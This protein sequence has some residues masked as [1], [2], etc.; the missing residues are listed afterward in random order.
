[1]PQSIHCADLGKMLTATVVLAS[2]LNLAYCTALAETIRVFQDGTGDYTDIPSGLDAAAE[3]D[4]VLVGAGRY[5]EVGDLQWGCCSS[6]TTNVP[7]SVPEIT[8]IGSGRDA[9]IIGPAVRAAD[10]WG[11]AGIAS[12]QP[13]TSLRV[14]SLTI[15]NLLF[16]IFVEGALDIWDLRIMGISNGVVFSDSVDTTL[17]TG[18]S[19]VN[20]DEAG[21]H[22]QSA[23]NV[24]VS[25]CE[26]TGQSTNSL[27]IHNS[28][29][30]HFVNSRSEDAWIGLGSISQSTLTVR[31]S[32]VRSGK[33]AGAV[34]GRGSMWVYDSY[35]E[36]D[37]AAFL[38]FSG[39]R[40][41]F[42]RSRLIGHQV[43]VYLGD[44]PDVQ[45]SENDLI[46]SGQWTVYLDDIYDMNGEKLD[47][48]NNWWGTTDLDSIQSWILDADNPIHDND[49]R[50]E[51]YA[52]F[53]PILEGSV[54]TRKQTVGGLKG[55]FREP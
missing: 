33:D 49:P 51:G 29:N 34:S 7:I 39:A 42:H 35:F 9:T 22:L 30:V 54:P 44:T 48:R 3:G 23:D 46:R 8:I 11:T 16:G 13:M 41:E 38:A 19:F 25:G 20:C 53:L 40:V 52:E 15:E 43:T 28:Q 50:E 55:R 5:T 21:I 2:V 26:F 36:G 10:D 27:T 31:D 4:T 37:E 32:Y 45:F 6:L 18:C 17:I 47:F 1:M 12:N 24:W 14:E